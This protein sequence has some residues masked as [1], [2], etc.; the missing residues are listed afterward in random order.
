MDRYWRGSASAVISA[1]AYGLMPIFARRAYGMGVGVQELLLVRFVL[2][3]LVIGLFLRLT[4]RKSSPSRKQLPFLLALGGI[5]YFTLANLYFISLLYIPVSV[6]ALILYTYPAL[7]TMGSLALGWERAS[8]PLI[9]ALSLALLG[10][11]LVVNPILSVGPIGFLM[12]FGAAVVYTI[13]IL[14]S[15]RVLRGLGGDVASLYVAGSAGVSFLLYDALTGRMNFGWGLEA[16]VWAILIAVVSTAIAGTA[17]FQA[18]KLIGPSKAS[19]LSLIE[20]ITSIVAASVVFGE[21]LGIN[22]L[23]GGALIL[24]ATVIAA[25][26]TRT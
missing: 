6:V 5:G 13:Y 15:T 11:Y 9:S 10:L 21:F 24:L 26:S 17:F 8:M 22:Q 1:V 14:V 18:V 3:F 12:T 20:P 4:R 25:V 7:V 2:A 16:W 19:I 23:I